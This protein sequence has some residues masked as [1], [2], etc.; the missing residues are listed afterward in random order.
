VKFFSHNQDFLPDINMDKN[1]NP[2]ANPTISATKLEF[3][4]LFNLEENLFVFK[5]R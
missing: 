4:A 2:G 3:K 1:C 5:M